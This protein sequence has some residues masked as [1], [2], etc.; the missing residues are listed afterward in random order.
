MGN[1][2]EKILESAILKNPGFL[3]PLFG[4][5]EGE[6]FGLNAPRLSEIRT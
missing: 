5:G 2:R 6:I 1:W 4:K 3:F